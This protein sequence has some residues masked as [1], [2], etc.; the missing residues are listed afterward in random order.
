MIPWPFPGGVETTA[1][2]LLMFS[3]LFAAA[4]ALML[5]RPAQW[6]RTAAKV[7]SVLL[8]VAIAVERDGPGLLAA[9]LVLSAAGDAFLAYKD[10]RAFL[11]GLASFL[12]AHLVYVALFAT[13]G[14][15]AALP[16]AFAAG[17]VVAMAAFVAVMGWLIVPA[18]GRALRLPVV[19]YMAAIFAMGAAAAFNANP[20]V[21]AGVVLFM[22]SDAALGAARFVVAA[23]HRALPALHLFVWIAYWLAQATIL[24]G[25]TG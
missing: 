6:R 2:G 1:N 5:E 19:G 15:G 9:A 17:A 20:V 18:V 13:M 14:G 25:M 24:V 10:E 22:A 4:Y 12:V 23:D 16:A 21:L 7:G 3:A 8:L 11:G